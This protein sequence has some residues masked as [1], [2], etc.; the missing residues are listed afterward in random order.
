MKIIFLG[1]PGSGKGT[2]SS[3]IGPKYGIPHIST[4]DI[5]RAEIKAGTELGKKVEEILKAGGLVPDEL[6]MEV[7]KKRLS[8]PDCRNGFIADGFPRTIAQADALEKI[9]KVDIVLNLVLPDDIIIEKISSR[10]TCK[11][12]GNIYNIADISREGIRMPPM[13]PKAEGKCDKCGGELIQRS[14]ER[15]EIIKGRLEVYKKQTQPLIDYY[16]GKGLLK[17]IKV[18]SPPDEM[19]S[20]ILE[21]LE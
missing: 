10:R 2:Y 11:N 16:R 7:I 20:K 18:D 8:Q 13:L 4:G 6:T 12:C 19:V 5:F 14:D 1:P 21:V 17:D 3:R 15:P 9:A